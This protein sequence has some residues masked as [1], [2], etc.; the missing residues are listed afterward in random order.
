MKRMIFVL[1]LVFAVTSS[2][3]ARADGEYAA[4]LGWGSLA[5]L[6]NVFYMPVKL[7][8]A[9]LGGITGTLAYGLT[10]GDI[11]TAEAVWHPTMGGDYVVTPRMLNGKESI[12][13]SPTRSSRTSRGYGRL[14]EDE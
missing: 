8:Y 13:F 10:L 7:V 2:S 5:V 3:V 12:D 6:C 14:E 4:E 9:T 1:A 11:E